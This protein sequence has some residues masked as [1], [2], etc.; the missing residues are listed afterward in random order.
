MKRIPLL[1]T[2]LS[3]A[4]SIISC[5]KDEINTDTTSGTSEPDN[6]MTLSEQNRAIEDLPCNRQLKMV[7]FKIQDSDKMDDHIR[8]RYFGSKHE[9]IHLHQA[10]WD[11]N[12]DRA[13]A[14]EG[15]VAKDV[16]VNFLRDNNGVWTTKYP[17]YIAAY[18]GDDNQRKYHYC[19]VDTNLQQFRIIREGNNMKITNNDRRIGKQYPTWGSCSGRA[20][21]KDISSL[22]D[23]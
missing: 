20:F 14:N 13:E 18:G 22:L 8:L 17:A 19:L 6:F 5:S 23:E 12:T 11:N 4:T 15:A 21:N 16:V 7:N 10:F 1:L 3:L 2:A 9:D